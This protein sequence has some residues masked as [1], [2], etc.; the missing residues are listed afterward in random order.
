MSKPAI[1]I[2]NCTDSPLL[3]FFRVDVFLAGDF[4]TTLGLFFNGGTVTKVGKCVNSYLQC[5]QHLPFLITHTPCKYNRLP[6]INAGFTHYKVT[7]VRQSILFN[8]NKE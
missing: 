4:R 3:F 2:L 6:C 1:T 5:F 8:S 7:I